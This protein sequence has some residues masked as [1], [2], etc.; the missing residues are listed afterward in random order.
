MLFPKYSRHLNKEICVIFGAQW[1]LD[2]HSNF[3]VLV[4]AKPWSD[5]VTNVNSVARFLL[6]TLRGE[7]KRN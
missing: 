4:Y 6:D 1:S 3:I 2:V 7:K 5:P